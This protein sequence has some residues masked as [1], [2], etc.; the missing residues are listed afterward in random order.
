[1]N[2]PTVNDA[3]AGSDTTKLCAFCA[4]GWCYPVPASGRCGVCGHRCRPAS[5]T[6]E[7]AGGYASQQPDGGVIPAA[8]AP[9]GLDLDPGDPPGGFP[10]ASG[11]SEG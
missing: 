2:R 3:A 10:A 5:G 8:G 1:M 7:P 4:G 11:G 9:S 6:A